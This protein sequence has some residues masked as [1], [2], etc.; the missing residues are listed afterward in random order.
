MAQLHATISGTA[1]PFD[2]IEEY[3]ENGEPLEVKIEGLEHAKIRPGRHI[4]ERFSDFM[5]FSRMDPDCSLAEGN[6]PLIRAGRPLREFTGLEHLRL[7]N[8]T[9]NPTW[10][11][12]DRGSLTCMFMAKEMGEQV[13]ATISTGNMGHSIAAYSAKSGMTALVFVPHFTP[14]EKLHAMTIHGATVIRVHAPDYSMMKRQILGMAGR[15]RL[16]I[17]SGN[18]P[19]RVE[20][21]KLTAFEMFEQ[22]EGQ[23]PD[24]IAVPTSACGHVRGLFKGYAELKRAGM[25]QNLPRMIIVQ[26]RNNS[27]IVSAIKQRK[28]H[29]IPF[30]TFHTIAEAITSGTPEGGDELIDKAKRHGW[31]AED[32]TED[33]ILVSQR[34][35]AG[36]GLFVEPAAAT[37]LG[38]VRSL[39]QQGTIQP[40]AQ[41][42]LMLTGSGMKDLDVFKFHEGGIVE[43]DLSRVE[44]DVERIIT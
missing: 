33:E 8:E 3:A 24:Y 27:P 10:S 1:Y 4:W 31:L 2:R 43:S 30:S 41:V 5:P 15:L 20:G 6:T 13:T 40:D 21:Y 23:V 36:D 28:D 25:I 12:K 37:T 35:L 29:I 26:A 18:G 44:E 32:V 14:H 19:V 42:V 22:M 39:R 9:Q 17:V 38:A 16:R 7:K 11:F 34:R